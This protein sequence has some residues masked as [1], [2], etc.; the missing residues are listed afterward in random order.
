[1]RVWRLC[2][3]AHAAFDGEGARLF[4]GR[5]NPRGVAL[6]YT[7]ATASLAVLESLV[8]V[9][10]EDDPGDRVFVAADLPEDVS[11]TSVSVKSL[12]HD[13]RSA[14]APESLQAVG[15]SWARARKTAVLAVPSAILPWESNY[16]LNPAH[17]D[18]ARVKI[19]KPE[20]FA[21]DRRLLKKPHRSP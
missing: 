15:L 10:P 6:V 12:A 1:M 3:R 7:S 9:D 8:H 17:S 11:M 18:F 20:P 4:G 19:G 13:W 5:W 16:L 21:F 2:L 14:T